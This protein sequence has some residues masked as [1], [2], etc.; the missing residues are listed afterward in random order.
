V[1]WVDASGRV[2]LR[3]SRDGGATFGPPARL[4][5]ALKGFGASLGF[6]SG[7]LVAAWE[8]PGGAITVRR[9]SAAGSGSWTAP[10]SL[11]KAAEGFPAAVAARGSA[12]IV[13]YTVALDGKWRA[14]V[15]VSTDR[16]L[17]WSA[18]RLAQ[19]TGQGEAVTGVVLPGSGRLQ[20]ITTR[21]VSHLVDQVDV[22][23]ATAY[24]L[25]WGAATRLSDP[26]YLAIP[27]AV[28]LGSRTL[29][30]FGTIS[31]M[32]GTTPQLALYVGRV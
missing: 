5:T 7:A 8:A 23:P 10:V 2:T 21:A 15:R 28:A 9:N 14:V 31:G 27:D 11:D 32:T 16:G 20:L 17:H 1:S 26:R 29:V 30:L 25:S 6:S 19:A 18:R 24:G 22:V 13:A 12:V 3:L 4:G